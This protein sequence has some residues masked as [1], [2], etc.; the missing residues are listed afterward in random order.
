[1]A[2]K[3]GYTMGRILIIDDENLV[4]WS[5]EKLLTKE[6]H[7]VISA[8]TSAEGLLKLREHVPDVVLLDM[9]LPDID[10]IEVLRTIKKE[11]INLPV[12]MITAYGSID[13]AVDAIKTGAF[14]YIVKPFDAEKLKISIARA[15]EMSKLRDELGLFKDAEK[16]RYGFNSIIGDS[17]TIRVVI[18]FAK[19]IAD[20]QSTVLLYGESG[21]GKE[22]FARAIHSEGQRQAKPFVAVNC[23]A[24]PSQLIE[25]EL[26]G[27]EKGAFTDARSSKKG[28]FELANSGT[29]FLDEIGD[30]ELSVQS[31]LL[32]AIETK[33]FRRLGGTKDIYVDVRII[34]ATNSDLRKRVDDKAFREDLFYRL[35]VVPLF[36]P[37]LRNRKHD[38]PLLV[39]YFIKTISEEL[40]KEIRAVENEV[41]DYFT[42]YSWPGNIREL[43]NVLERMIL[44]SNDKLLRKE[45]VPVEIID[46]SPKPP[47]IQTESLELE[48]VEKDLILKALELAGWNQTKAA[49][50]LSISRDT[51]RYRMKK[52]NI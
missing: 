31:K 16:K 6:G 4:R 40:K 24:L 20:S 49:K 39:D 37:P 7:E 50:S 43:K 29:L 21:T 12:V 26:F 9:K 19:K 1:M 42:N 17:E 30:I 25:S 48:K 22:L 32:R 52:Y 11:F 18:D 45:H 3:E 44:L 46:Y 33:N 35:N 10:G 2:E 13:S 41:I 27:Y 36:I 8:S 51:L 15:L 38:I 28:M 23:T 14:D 34:S 47:F 5:I